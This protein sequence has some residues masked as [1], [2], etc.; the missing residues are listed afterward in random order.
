MQDQAYWLR[1]LVKQSDGT[2]CD[3]QLRRMAKMAET[4]YLHDQAAALRKAVAA[5]LNGQTG[6]FDQAGG[7]GPAVQGVDR[8]RLKLV[9]TDP[10]SDHREVTR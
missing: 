3:D 1:Q 10:S 7:I 4:V 5:A 8:A 9:S 6:P 2:L